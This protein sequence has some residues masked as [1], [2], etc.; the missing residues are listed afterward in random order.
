MARRA[1]RSSILKWKNW[2]GELFDFQSPK[3]DTQRQKNL[4]EEDPEVKVKC[5]RRLDGKTILPIAIE[6]HM[7]R[8]GKH[9]LNSFMHR[10]E[11]TG[12][13]DGGKAYFDRLTKLRQIALWI[14]NQ[15]RVNSR[16]FMYWIYREIIL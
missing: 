2:T 4:N 7:T 5:G 9:Q 6:L 13:C 3:W 10:V 8:G 11:R 1:S 16:L 12:L 14:L 15:H